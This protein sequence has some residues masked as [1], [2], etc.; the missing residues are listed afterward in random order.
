M[1]IKWHEIGHE[2][3]RTRDGHYPFLRMMPNHC[4][5]E[6]YVTGKWH[7]RVAE[8]NFCRKCRFQV[9]KKRIH[10]Q[11]E[12]IDIPFFLHRDAKDGISSM[13]NN[14]V[15]VTICTQQKTPHS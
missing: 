2:R 7:F 5:N 6:S 12:I 8:P 11:S 9:K 13:T 15:I 10:N 4:Q 3:A 1:R 14:L